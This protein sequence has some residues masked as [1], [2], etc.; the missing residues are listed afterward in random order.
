MRTWLSKSGA[1]I[2]LF[3]I[4]ISSIPPSLS[5]EIDIDDLDYESNDIDDITSLPSGSDVDYFVDDGSTSYVHTATTSGTSKG[6]SYGAYS[7]VDWN[8]DPS[9]HGV[10]VAVYEIDIVSS[11]LSFYYKLRA[12]S[13][14]DSDDELVFDFYVDGEKYHTNEWKKDTSDWF[15]LEIVGL[16]EE[17]HTYSWVHVDSYKWTTTYLYWDSVEF[18][19]NP[20]IVDTMIDYEVNG[21]S[22]TVLSATIDSGITTGSATYQNG[23]GV[24]S[25]STYVLEGEYSAYMGWKWEENYGDQYYELEDV[26]STYISFDYALFGG[27]GTYSDNVI[28]KFYIDNTL[29]HTETQSSGNSGTLS[30]YKDG[31]S[32]TDH[33][34]KWE[35]IDPHLYTTTYITIDNIQFGDGYVTKETYSL[36]TDHNYD[37]NE[38]YSFTIERSGAWNMRLYFDCIETYSSSD[39]IKIKDKDG[40]LIQTITGTYT[41]GLWSTNIPGDK[42]TLEWDTDSSGTDYGF[43]VNNVEAYYLNRIGFSS[44]YENSIDYTYIISKPDIRG[45]EDIFT[46]TDIVASRTAV[47]F[48]SIDVESNADYVKIYDFDDDLLASV[49]GS[50][51]EYTAGYVNADG[52]IIK[53]ETDSSVVDDGFIIDSILYSSGDEEDS[54]S[55]WA[56]SVL[57]VGDY[58]I[59]GDRYTYDSED[60]YDGSREQGL[61]ITQNEYDRYVTATDF[62]TDGDQGDMIYFG[63]HG[64]TGRAH[65]SEYNDSSEPVNE[66]YFAYTDAMDEEIG[67]NDLEWILFNSCNTV[68]VSG[69]FDPD[70]WVRNGVHIVMGHWNTVTDNEAQDL[71]TRFQQEAFGDGDTILDAWFYS[72]QVERP[73]TYTYSSATFHEANENDH[74]W[75]TGY[76]TKDPT[77]NSDIYSWDYNDWS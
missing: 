44:D 13:D 31:L 58:E 62:Y 4:T 77:T 8:N 34:F 73:S 10:G 71:A 28:M 2:I 69:T 18:Y 24:T 27:A 60:W 67:D 50:Q 54:S 33:D 70:H 51:T 3:I 11:G 22:D 47:I 12:S 43:S 63:G 68:Q 39:T 42:I 20:T 23:P 40:T 30:F 53:L 15:Y 48:E 1:L 35:C 46:D 65:L 64:G 36:S 45:T 9:S 49:T 21:Y 59:L 75:G 38:D 72:N 16:H 52:T 41:D 61:V 6:G 66:R 14:G 76:V 26:Q 74:F 55:A 17:S 25:S 5:E 37:N 32:D 56:M 57:G 19:S 7:K 29:I